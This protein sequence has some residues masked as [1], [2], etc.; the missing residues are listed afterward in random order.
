MKQATRIQFAI[1]LGA[2]D[3]DIDRLGVSAEHYTTTIAHSL[4]C[5]AY[6]GASVH[7]GSGIWSEKPGATPTI[8][9]TLYLTADTL[10]AAIGGIASIA[11]KLAKLFK[12][13]AVHVSYWP[14]TAGDIYHAS[15]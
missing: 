4:L 1:G 6:G 13:Q 7:Y 2:V 8:E 15:D 11:G 12:Q 9:R 10:P 14:I 5:S 3:S